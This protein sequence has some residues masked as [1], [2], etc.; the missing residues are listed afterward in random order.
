MQH[1]IAAFKCDGRTYEVRTFYH[2]KGYSVQVHK[3]DKAVGPKYSVSFET[4]SDYKLYTGASAVDQLIAVAKADIE[5]GF[6]KAG[7]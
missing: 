7:S 3:D 6:V 2:D 5:R 1:S 4:A